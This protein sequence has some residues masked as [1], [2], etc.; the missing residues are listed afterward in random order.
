M[1]LGVI[2]DDFTGASDI[3]NTLAKG[4]PGEGGLRTAQ[5][6]GVPGPSRA[7]AHRGR[8]G[9]AEEPLHRG[10]RRR[11]AVAR[12]ARLAAGAG[13][14][15]VRV[16]IL[17][18]LRFDA[19]GQY[20]PGRRGAWPCARREGRRGLPGLSRRGA[21]RL[22]G[23]PLRARPAPERIR[24]AEPS[25]QPDDGSGPAP[26]ARSADEDARRPRRLAGGACRRGLAQAGPRR[27]GRSAA[28]R[29][30]SSTPSATTIW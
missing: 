30:S 23:P 2:A 14:P 28:R 21:H 7:A 12:R 10:R 4:L 20:R 16:Q 6:L 11:R 5:F 27:G 24:H 3:A 19:R 18:H 17:L 1:L 13:L 22:S 15:P 29:W 9:G 25:A 8:R 26:L